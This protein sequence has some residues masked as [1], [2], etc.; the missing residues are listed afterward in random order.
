MRAAR[1]PSLDALLAFD[2]VARA[3]SFEA[4]AAELALTP[5][6][7]AKRVAGLE[8]RLDQPLFLRQ[9]SRGLVLTPAGHEYLPQVRQALALLQAIPLHQRESPRRE[10]LRI[11]STPTFARQLLVPALPDFTAAH[12]HI[13]LE[14]TLSVPLLAEGDAGADAEIRHGAVPTDI[15]PAQVLLR[16]RLTPLAAPALLARHGPLRRPADLLALPL[17]RTPLQPW[18]PW[19]RAAGLDE[20][21][22]PDDGPR[23]V[24]LGLTLAAA[25]AGQGVALARLSLARHELAE[26]RLVQP[27]ALTVPAE[28]HYGLVRHRSG[29]AV[30]AFAGWLYHHCRS[31]DQPA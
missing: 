16:D 24:D 2:A 14:L 7:V 6:A 27:F 28:R 12:P 21:A 26:G 29:P 8:E 22:E 4:A 10:R 23:F 1:L 17:L 13:E 31:L 18:S 20:A 9:P 19:L 15:A 25:L 5:S 11:S 3:G 30:E